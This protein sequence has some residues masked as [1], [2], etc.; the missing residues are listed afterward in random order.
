[1]QISFGYLKI[2]VCTT[3]RAVAKQGRQILTNFAYYIHFCKLSLTDYI[4]FCKL[5]STSA[6]LGHCFHCLCKL[7]CHDLLEFRHCKMTSIS[8]HHRA[9]LPGA[10]SSLPTSFTAMTECLLAC[11]DHQYCV[12][13]LLSLPLHLI[14][15]LPHTQY[16][17]EPTL[18]R[19]HAQSNPQ[20]RH[21][22]R[23]KNALVRA[24]T[25]Y[26]VRRNK[27]TLLQQILATQSI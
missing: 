19:L 2:P 1:M 25:S 22:R 26:Q 17:Q 21:T 15:S 20:D 16:T 18:A 8:N 27:H 11:Y 14:T 23:N 6:L 24:R 9:P 13:S 10:A 7:P 12:I 5:S 3:S 4:D